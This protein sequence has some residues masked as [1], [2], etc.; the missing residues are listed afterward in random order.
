M[1]GVNI[2][3]LAI[4]IL[5]ICMSIFRYIDNPIIL[6]PLSYLVVLGDV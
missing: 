3:D 5:D 6:I 2:V 1:G 4:E